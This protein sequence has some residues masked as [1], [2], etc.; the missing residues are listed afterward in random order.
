MKNRGYFG[1]GIWGPQYEENVGTLFRSAV[2]FGASFIFTIGRKYK[3]QCTDTVNSTGKIP[4]FK[5][6][7]SEDF[8]KSLPDGCQIVCVEISD[9]SRNL[10]NFCHPDKSVY[11]LGNECMGIPEKFMKDKMIVQIPTTYCLNVASAG[12][13]VMYD[14]ISKLLRS[15]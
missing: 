11:L 3:R 15:Q 12:T 8:V 2:C 7:S 1:I 5:Y 10:A 6:V 13:V 4:Y 14:R 9:K